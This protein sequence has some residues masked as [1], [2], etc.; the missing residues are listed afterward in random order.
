MTVRAGAKCHRSP[1]PQYNPDF[2]LGMGWLYP[3]L[4]GDVLACSWE[5]GLGNQQLNITQKKNWFRKK[6]NAS[7]TCTDPKAGVAHGGWSM[8]LK[9]T[10]FR[11]HQGVHSRRK[12]ENE[13][14][15]AEIRG[16]V[17]HSPQITQ[18]AV[19]HS[20]KSQ[21]SLC[22]WQIQ[23]IWTN[24]PQKSSLSVRM[25]CFCS[26]SRKPT[27]FWAR[28]DPEKALSLLWETPCSFSHC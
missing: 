8:R 18:P 19:C 20:K 14:S 11:S 5:G 4:T 28:N 26:C 13:R 27:L 25:F 21:K 12:Q 24:K 6:Q 16:V 17:P 10:D 2:L 7:S 15:L 1:N 9:V 3:L 23:W 22:W